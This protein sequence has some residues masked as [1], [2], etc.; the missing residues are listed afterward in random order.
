[1]SS[2]VVLV[3]GE[4]FSV[5]GNVQICRCRQLGLPEKHVYGA[6]RR[7]GFYITG[8]VYVQ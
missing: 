6:E 3:P 2:A 7:S 5:S 1:M 4:G 8:S